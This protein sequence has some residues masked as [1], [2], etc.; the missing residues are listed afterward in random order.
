[1]EFV[2]VNP[3]STG[4]NGL[5]TQFPLTKIRLLTNAVEFRLGHKKVL[6]ETPPSSNLNILQVANVITR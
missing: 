5:T 4:K 2:D 1:V 6:D 3:T